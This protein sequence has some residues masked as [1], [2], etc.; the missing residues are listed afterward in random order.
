MELTWLGTAGF[1]VKHKG[2][3]FAFDPFLSRGAGASS[4]FGASDFANSRAIFIGHGHFDHTYDVPA[5]AR[6]SEAIVFAP[7][8][9]GLL[10]RV[11]GL[12]KNRLVPAL[13]KSP[14][15]T[16]VKM[17]AFRSAHVDFDWPLIQSTA[18]RCGFGGCLHV[19]GLGVRFPKG[20]VQTYYFELAHKKFLFISTG[21][22]TELELQAYRKLEVDYLLAPLQGHSEISRI[23]ADQVMAIA[24]KVVIPHHHDDF[25]PPLSQDISTLQL[26]E[27]LEERGFKGKFLELPLFGSCLL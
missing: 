18:K 22:C 6:E 2:I 27:L 13:P 19:A 16:D 1:I 14:L 3:E 25:Y 17:Q 11:R 7:G 10:L 21:G 12:P 20:L 5:I 26:K 4:P 9:T 15:L 23:C 24:P 8:L